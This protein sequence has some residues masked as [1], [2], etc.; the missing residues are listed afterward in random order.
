MAH[1][2]TERS[3]VCVM[4]AWFCR[5]IA[6]EERCR[7]VKGLESQHPRMNSLS[8]WPCGFAL[9]GLGAG[10]TMGGC[11]PRPREEVVVGACK[12]AVRRTS[13]HTC[14]RSDIGVGGASVSMFS[15][16]VRNLGR[17]FA[18][19][20]WSR[21]Y[22]AVSS[23][24]WVD[25]VKLS[26]GTD[27]PYAWSWMDFVLERVVSSVLPRLRWPA[28][29]E[30]WSFWISPTWLKERR[31]I[32]RPPGFFTLVDETWHENSLILQDLC[33]KTWIGKV[34]VVQFVRVLGRVDLTPLGVFRWSS[35]PPS[36]V[37]VFFSL[38][39]SLHRPNPIWSWLELLG[40]QSLIPR[41][42]QYQ[43]RFL[44]LQVPS[45][46]LWQWLSFLSRPERKLS[47]CGLLEL[48]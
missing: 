17:C 38:M 41:L 25:V 3:V 9:F 15:H 16:D 12:P 4:N 18:L 5:S 20:S 22:R 47:A 36:V 48:G 26:Q 39:A 24:E 33:G 23:M 2:L 14:H 10:L 13:W 34:S 27:H 21:Y 40:K 28:Q 43:R 30:P 31:L 46:S 37:S 42:S 19:E 1:S 6:G 45:R 29:F 35:R 44:E 7:I 8:S 11:S 32:L